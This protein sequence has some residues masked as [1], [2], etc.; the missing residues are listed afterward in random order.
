MDIEEA[1]LLRFGES[2]SEMRLPPTLRGNGRIKSC[3]TRKSLYAA[4]VKWVSLLLLN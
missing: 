3:E 4:M 1:G 2:G